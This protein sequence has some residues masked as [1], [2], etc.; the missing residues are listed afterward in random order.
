MQLCSTYVYFGD[1]YALLEISTVRN[2]YSET[3]VGHWL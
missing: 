1:E 2:G 3:Q